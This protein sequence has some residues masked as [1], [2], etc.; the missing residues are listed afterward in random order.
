MDRG[1]NVIHK[2]A[3]QRLEWMDVAKG[4]AIILMVVGHTSIPKSLSDFI[5]AFHMPL[6]FIASGWLTNWN[7]NTIQDFIC[8]KS[9]NL[10]L[11]FLSYSMI[12]LCVRCL[13]LPEGGIPYLIYWL[14]H[15]W[16]GIALWFIP[17]LFAALVISKFVIGLREDWLIVGGC[18]VLAL[19]GALLSHYRIHLPW[20]LSSIP[21]A[22]AL[23]IM[24]YFAKRSV[25]CMEKYKGIIMIL[26]FGVTFIISRFYTL[27]I[28]FNSVTPVFL[29]TIG[30]VSG[31]AMTFSFS[32][33][34]LK[35][36][37]MANLFQK[38]G[39]ETFIILG[40]SQIIIVVLKE[41]TG[42]GS[43]LRYSILVIVLILFK[44]TKD[45]INHRLGI[46]I[47]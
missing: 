8:N 4:I 3:N 1:E 5:W 38:V 22:T 7:R 34:L 15:G 23:V 41:Y 10:L 44:Y 17:V 12:V 2:D 16:N 29:L 24:G 20:T 42:L 28:C 46:K 18:I 19:F 13:L 21:Y 11:P 33:L 45:A 14:T 37:Y 43:V 47:L 36:K 6:F 25:G 32:F 30:A 40:L 35:T 27:D 9:K 26:G 31:V 39:Q